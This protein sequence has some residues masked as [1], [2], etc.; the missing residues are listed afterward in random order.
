MTY[1]YQ[2]LDCKNVQEE[3]H[4]MNDKP[5]IICSKCNSKKMKKMVSMGSGIIF[6]GGGWSNDHMFKESMTKENEIAG[7]KA[8]AH[9]K[10]VKTLGD[11]A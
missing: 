5:K 4:G 9:R 1:D 3:M 11:L 2:C 7:R 8:A 10:P 6:K